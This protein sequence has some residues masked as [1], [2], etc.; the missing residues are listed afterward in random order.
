MWIRTFIN[1][2]LIT[3]VFGRKLVHEISEYPDTQYPATWSPKE[4]GGDPATWGPKEIGG[5]P[6]TWG[7]KEIGGDPVLG[8]LEL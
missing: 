4:I 2:L 7:P 8:E 6:S 1:L 5:D 3:S